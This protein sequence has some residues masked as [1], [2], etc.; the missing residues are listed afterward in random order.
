[1]PRG[2]HVPAGAAPAQ[3]GDTASIAHRWGLSSD[4]AERRR[5][6]RGDVP[7]PPTS[8]SYASIVRAN[9]FTVF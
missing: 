1:M 5:L 9:V 6:E 8:R 4:E 3:G 2:L 7:P